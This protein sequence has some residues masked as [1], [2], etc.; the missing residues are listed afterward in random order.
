MI[1]RKP[2]T[3]G[4]LFQPPSVPKPTSESAAESVKP[5]A[6]RLRRMVLDHIIACGGCTDAEGQAALGMDGNTYRPRR[7]EL[8]RAGMVRDSGATR[9]TASGRMATVYTLAERGERA[10]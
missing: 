8:E 5:S 6:D 3:F 2:T 4:P 7:W 10:A 9:R 1:P